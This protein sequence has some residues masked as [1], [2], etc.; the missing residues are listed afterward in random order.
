MG[1]AKEIARMLEA[2]KTKVVFIPPYCKLR[3]DTFEQV[4]VSGNS[5]NFRTF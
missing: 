5:K 4:C 1:K 3:N 2:L